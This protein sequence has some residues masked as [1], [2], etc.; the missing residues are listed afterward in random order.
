[1]KYVF[2]VCSFIFC[3]T[4]QAQDIPQVEPKVHSFT[5]A[6]PEIR[7]FI[8]KNDK[9]VNDGLLIQTIQK[10]N[11]SGKFDISVEIMPWAR[12]LKEVREGRF[13]AL[14]PTVYTP[15]R[16]TFLSFPTKPLINFY[17]SEI[18][19][20]VDDN[21]IYQS[22]PL[23]D[24]RKT[25]VKV[26][27]TSVDQE[28]EKAFKKASIKFFEATRLEDAFNMLIYGHVDLLLADSV[29]AQTTINKMEINDSV[30]GFLL[31]TKVH[32]SFLAFS[33]DFAKH[34]DINVLMDK[35]NLINAPDSYH[36]LSQK[37]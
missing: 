35:I 21:F 17:G 1:M 6:A 29:I 2:W 16:A 12:A 18:F 14:M 7:P 23:I 32:S 36:R 19:K 24:N 3:V 27:S 9:G 15:E 37:K 13:D 25:F 11:Q 33:T 8:F 28:S 31:T 30:K 22:I 34:Q 4:L 5:I 26:R 20:R 10:L